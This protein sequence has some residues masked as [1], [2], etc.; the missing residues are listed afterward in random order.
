[1]P[2]GWLMR[3]VVIGI[4]WLALVGSAWAVDYPTRSVRVLTGYP[5]GGAADVIGRV[6]VD[7]LTNSLGQ[8]FYLEGKPG[9][10][11]NLAGD[12]LANAAP[13]GYTLYLAGFGV[14]T[15]NHALYH[16]MTYDPATA[17]APITLLAR[18]P[19]VIEVSAKL[20]VTTFQDFVAYAKSH[21]PLN[22]GS[23]GIGTP[24]HLTATLLAAKLGI[25]SAHIPYRGSGPFISAM[26]Q[27]EVDWGIDVPNAVMTLLSAKAVKAIAVTSRAREPTFPDVPSVAELGMPDLVVEPWFALVAPAA[28]PRAIIERVSTE[29]E[30]G[31]A[32]PDAAARLRQLGYEPAPTTPDEAA[33]IFAADRTRWSGVVVEHH[34]KAE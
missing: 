34:I 15:I 5:P 9:A 30:R 21:A 11:G 12:I 26:M 1:M 32:R 13:D 7:G 14:V 24:A 2:V 19:L 4:A 25:E 28:T 3:C 20:P 23:P 27:G 22:H 10:A 31:F 18:L 33:A 6:L 8:S 29:V 17:F 16:N